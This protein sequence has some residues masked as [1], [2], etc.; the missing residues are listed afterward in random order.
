MLVGLALLFTSM[1]LFLSYKRGFKDKKVSFVYAFVIGLAQ[2]VAIVPGVSRS[3]ATITT[4][5]LLGVGKSKAT[6][7]SFLM[8][9][10]PI[11]GAGVLKLKDYLE[12][13][14]TTSIAC[15]TLLTGFLS[16]FISGYLACVWMLNIVRKGKLSWF[17]GYCLVVGLIT[18]LS[19]V[20]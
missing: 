16:A 7:F 3:G 2:A 19:Q 4:A 13:T 9:L 10:I 5:L 12:G 14:E 8:V 1:L 6:K 11:L 18:I 20:F 15:S 17:A